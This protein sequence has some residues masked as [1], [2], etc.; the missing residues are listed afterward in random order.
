MPPAT[1]TQTY[2]TDR[3]CTVGLYVT[4]LNWF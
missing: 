4:G 2:A 3:V 1:E